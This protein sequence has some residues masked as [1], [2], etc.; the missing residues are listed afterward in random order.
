MENS[1]S[2]GTRRPQRWKV[3]AKFVMKMTSRK[4]MTLNNVLHVLDVQ[5]NLE[6]GSLLSK[7]GFRLVFE[8]DKFILANNGMYL[9]KDYLSNWLFMLNVMTVIPQVPNGKNIASYSTY[10]LVSFDLWHDRLEHVNFNTMLLK[11]NQTTNVK[12]E[13]KK[14]TRKLVQIIHS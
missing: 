13:L 12:F 1:C 4:E 14:L 6:L 2:W 7:H 11:L 9:R 10:M 5:K 3:K 8:V